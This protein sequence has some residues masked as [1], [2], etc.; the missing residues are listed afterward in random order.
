MET[1]FL[2]VICLASR[3]WAIIIESNILGQDRVY[4]DGRN[5]ARKNVLKKLMATELLNNIAILST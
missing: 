5:E 3:D 1:V 4:G 2:S